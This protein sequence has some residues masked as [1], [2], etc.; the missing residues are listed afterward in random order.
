MTSNEYRVDLSNAHAL[1]TGAGSGIGEQ[2]AR[3]LSSAGACES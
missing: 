1:V 2:V 3:A